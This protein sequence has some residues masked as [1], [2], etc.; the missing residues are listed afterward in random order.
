M[1]TVDAGDVRVHVAESG[2]GHPVVWI[3]GTG[4]LGSTWNRHQVSRFAARYRCITLDLRGSGQTEGGGANFTVA[5]LAQDVGC[6]LEALGAAP[7]HLVGLSLGSAVIQELAIRRPDL[8]RSAVLIGTWS[9]TAREHHIRRHFSSRLYALENGPLDVFAQFAFWMSAPSVI[10]D[11]PELQREVESELAAHTSQRPEGTAAHFR[12]DL[13]H[14]T[15]SRLG[16][17]TARTLILHGEEDLITLPRY[18]E[19]VAKLI[20]G[21]VIHAIPRAGHLVWLER[22][23]EVNDHID[24]FLAGGEAS[25]HGTEGTVSG[26]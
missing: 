12:A 20:P 4:L 17:I 3:P 26:S 10:D 19:R 8:V 11:E 24:R 22:P 15:E 7:A 21:A 13:S 6:L 5:D 9:S 23:R 18:N 2:T 16:Q 14:D 25:G 1:P